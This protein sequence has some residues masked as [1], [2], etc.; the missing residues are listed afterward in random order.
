MMDDIFYMREA[1]NEAKLALLE[2]EVPVGCVIVNKGKIIARSHNYTYKGKSAIKHAEVLAILEAN[3]YMGDFRLEDCIMYVTKEPC[4]MCA[5]AI[6]NSRIK[7][8]VIAMPDPIRGACG[9]NTNIL[10]DKNQLYNTEVE[11]G[12]LEEESKKIIQTFFKKLRRRAKEKKK[13]YK[14]C[15]KC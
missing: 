4:S 14:N 1:I 7:K 15:D 8:V 11:M 6:I 5:G 10:Q 12:L 3:K 13:L 9:S 2:E